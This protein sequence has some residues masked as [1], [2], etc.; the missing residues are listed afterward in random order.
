MVQYRM[1][2]RRGKTVTL[3]AVSR[4]TFLLVLIWKEVLPGS[5]KAALEACENPEIPGAV[6]RVEEVPGKDLAL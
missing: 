2:W 6:R 4:W 5:N 1:R 3:E